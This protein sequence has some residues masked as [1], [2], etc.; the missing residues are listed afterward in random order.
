MS[1]R[2][3]RKTLFYFTGSQSTKIS[4]CFDQLIM[5]RIQV[6]NSFLQVYK[7]FKISFVRRK[8]FCNRRNSS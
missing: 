8:S 6:G 4:W 1:E 2:V 7:A 3:F 5:V